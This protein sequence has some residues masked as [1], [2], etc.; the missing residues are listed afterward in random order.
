MVAQERMKAKEY[1]KIIAKSPGRSTPCVGCSDEEIGYC[2]D[3]GHL[4]INGKYIADLCGRFNNYAE[5][6]KAKGKVDK[7]KIKRPVKKPDVAGRVVI[8][9]VPEKLKIQG[10]W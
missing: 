4:K 9:E 7:S 1:R 6:S 10:K 3:H 2:A 8:K 5:K